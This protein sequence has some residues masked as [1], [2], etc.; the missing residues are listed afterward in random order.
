MRTRDISVETTSRQDGLQLLL[1][2]FE[3][4]NEHTPAPQV[5]VAKNKV[6]TSQTNGPI[7]VYT[8]SS[9]KDGSVKTQFFIKTGKP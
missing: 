7:Q 6:V 9:F 2:R 5:W 1:R 3:M 4:K 8:E